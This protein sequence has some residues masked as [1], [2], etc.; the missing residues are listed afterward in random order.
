MSVQRNICGTLAFLMSLDFKVVD[1]FKIKSSNAILK[2]P[3]VSSRN[4]QHVCQTTDTRVPNNRHTCQ[5]TNT[6]RYYTD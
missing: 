4:L 2:Y 1:N 3:H 5:K 6:L